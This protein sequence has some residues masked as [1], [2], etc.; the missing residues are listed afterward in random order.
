MFVQKVTYEIL[1]EKHE[2][3]LKKCENVGKEGIDLIAKLIRMQHANDRLVAAN[4]HLQ[5]LYNEL[6]KKTKLESDI[7][8]DTKN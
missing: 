8:R 1:K 3:L 6:L 4:K 5:N 7:S 2:K